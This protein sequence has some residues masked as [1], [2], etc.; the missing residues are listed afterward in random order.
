MNAYPISNKV[1]QPGPYNREILTPQGPRLLSEAHPPA[2]PNKS[3]Y[4]H[5]KKPSDNTQTMGEM[6]R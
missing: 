1:E 4:G 3:Y 2:L 6:V 5:K